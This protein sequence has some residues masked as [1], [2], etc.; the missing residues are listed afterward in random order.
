MSMG[1]WMVSLPVMEVVVN[2]SVGSNDG[3]EELFA[4]CIFDGGK[5]GCYVRD[6][7]ADILP[8]CHEAADKPSVYIV[9]EACG[10]SGKSVDAMYPCIDHGT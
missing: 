8:L 5:E 4:K 3:Q 6:D 2:W 7:V 1:L 10:N 9:R